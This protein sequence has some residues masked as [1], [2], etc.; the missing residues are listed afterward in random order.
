MDASAIGDVLARVNAGLNA[1]SL[2]LLVLGWLSIRAK[3]IERHRMLMRAAFLTSALFLA[4]YLVR[5]SLTGAHH[6]AATGWI[7]ATYLGILFSHMILAAATVPLVLR[8][9]YLAYKQRFAE[10]RR[11][12]RITFP[13]WAYVS[14]TGVI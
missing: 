3:K 14:L 10:H 5:Y 11:I 1:T 9:L 8:A 4:S 7:K 2:L 13:I 12:A 6:I